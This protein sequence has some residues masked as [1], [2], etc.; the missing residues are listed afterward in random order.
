MMT[1]YPKV[2]SDK[3]KW[4]VVAY[5]H[6]H[7]T[8]ALRAHIPAHTLHSAAHIASATLGRMLSTTF[9]YTYEASLVVRMSRKCI[10]IVGTVDGCG[11]NGQL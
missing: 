4:T 7:K 3:I 1:V 9:T 10:C 11:Y 8:R 5:G 6:S 2:G